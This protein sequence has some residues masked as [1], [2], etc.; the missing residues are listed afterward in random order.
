MQ[1]QSF[2]DILSA[3]LDRVDSALADE[4]QPPHWIAISAMDHRWLNISAANGA[5]ITPQRFH[6]RGADLDIRVG[7]PQLDQTH[8]IRDAG[9]F[10]SDNKESF[11]LPLGDDPAAIQLA[12]WRAADDA[13][14]QA[15]KRLLK[16][17][18][19]LAVKVESSDDSAD[20]S[21]AP[22]QIDLRE[23]AVLSVDEFEWQDRLRIA[24][25]RVTQSAHV[26]DSNLS[27]SAQAETRFL[28]TTDGTRLSLPRTH[29]RVS[30][31]LRTTADDGMDITVYE[32][33]DAVS[34]ADLPDQATLNAAVDAAAARLLALRAAP[35]VEPTIAPAILKGR[36]AA[37][38][39]HEVLGHRIEGHRQKDD[40]EGQTF[41][42]KIG[43][44]VLP[45]FISVIDDPTLASLSGT[46]LNGHYSHDDEG[47]A[48]Q[49]V[50][51]VDAGVLRNFLTSR[52]PIAGF[53]SSNGHG[54]RQMGHHVVSRQGNLLVEASESVSA[55]RLRSMLL[56]EVRRQG[57]PYGFIFEDITGGF[58]FTGRVTPNAFAVQPVGIVRVFADGRPDELVRGADLIGT[59]LT[60]FQQILA[61]SDE[62]QVFNGSCGA[63]SGWVPVS[64][65]APD[66]LIGE[67]EVQR[68]EKAHDRPPLLPPPGLLK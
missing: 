28:V 48:A 38:F 22:V 46:D 59:P 5:T 39:F 24:S 27:L 8:K 41:T 33:F 63:E 6:T 15:R 52:S 11:G 43:E 42:D 36:A 62:T 65:A 40:D 61:A 19:N 16:V 47:V 50:V 25:K 56:Q 26:L 34:A 60:T 1:A 53:P 17:Q 64:A 2:I 12:I 51:V 30:V 31:F 55:E 45:E 18:A 32:A 4:Q 66:L 9:W 58:T 68:S 37:V 29:F 13:Y 54:R 14:R 21:S 23:P 57:K 44:L 7:T 49:R 20:F 10:D 67:V 3:E 35:V